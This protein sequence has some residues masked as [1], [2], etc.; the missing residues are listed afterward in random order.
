VTQTLVPTRKNA[1]PTSYRWHH[2]G[3]PLPHRPVRV[4][5]GASPRAVGLEA[6]PWLATGDPGRPFD[7]CGH[8]RRLCADITR[9]CGEL[10]HID[11]GKLLIGVTQARSGVRHG[12]QARVT[13]LR[14]R[15]GQTTRRRDGVL[16][17]VQRYVVDGQEM[18]YL[19]TF[20][21]PRFL[22]QSFDDKFVTLFHELYHIS[23]AFEGDLRRMGGRCALHTRSQRAYDAQMALLARAYLASGADPALHAFLRLDHAQLAHRHGSVVGV[24]VPRPRLLPVRDEEERGAGSFATGAVGRM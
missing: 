19:V 4:P 9:R 14:F 16:Y 12:L 23:P 15:H 22:D 10:R 11:V 13:P 8:V 7:F 18:L 21:L 1:L 20:C 5:A 6:P 3:K 2:P 17:Q 24:T